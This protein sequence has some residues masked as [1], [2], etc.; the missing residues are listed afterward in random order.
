MAIER[1]VDEIDIDELDI[2]DNSKE[3]LISDESEDE[4]MFD[5]IEDG[6]E[7]ILEDGTMVFGE[8]DLDEDIPLPFTANLA[9]ELD[10][11]DLGRIYSD[12]MGD[13]DDDKSSRKEWMDQYT[14]GLKFLGM[15]FENRTEPFDGASGVIHPLLAESV[16]Q[17]QAQA[18]KEMLPAG[19]PVKTNV[20]GMGTPQTDLQAAR[21][22]EY[23]NYM[24]TQEMKEYDP[25]TDQLLFYLPLSGSAFR[26]V[27]FDQSLG[28]P[29]SRFIP[30]EK[31]I[32]P[33]GTTSLD[34]AVRITHVIDMSM[35]QVRKLQQ[36]GF[37]KKTSMSDSGNDYSDTDQIDEEIDELQ[38][39]KPSGS[40]NDYECELLEVH[41]ELDIPGYEDVDQM[42]E[43]TGIKLPYIVTLSPKQSTILSI[44]RNYVQAD[45][46]RKRIDYFVH[47]KFLPG[48]GFYGFGLTHMI[49]GLSQ[50]STSILRQ[51]IDAGTLANLPAGF[52][53]RGIRIRDNDIPLQPGEFRDMDAPGGSLRD[54]LMPLPFKE[55][56]QTL[57]QL[58]GM[59]V[60]AGR[61]FASVGDMQVGDGNQQ[62]PVGTTIALLE[63]GSRV[64]SAI[65]KRMHYSQR[66]EFNLLARVIKDSPLKSYP[67]MI[68]SGQQQLMAQDFD[69]RIDIIP[70]SDPNIF[71]MSQRV[72][73][74]QEMMQMVQTNPE[75]HG[76]QGTYEAYRRMYEAMG[77]Q[78]IEQLL[79]PPPQPQPASPGM[80]NAA[81]LQMQP[82]QAF[83]DQDHDAHIKSHLLLLKSPVVQNAPPG[84][85]QLMGLIQGHI[86]QHIDLKAREMAQQDPEVTQ[87]QQQIQQMQQQAQMDPMMQQQMQ[88]QMQ[89][90]QQQMQT[91]VE[92]KVAQ[93]TVE[94]LNELEEE[95]QIGQEEDPLVG[96]RKEELDLKDKDIDR[97][98][99]EAQQRI[100]LEGDRIDNNVE[101]GQDRLALQDHT[102]HLKDD[103]A[104][105]RIDLQR[106]AQMAKTAENMAKNFFNN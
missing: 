51:L 64:M 101:L 92:D 66:I 79:P 100:K 61:R 57:L 56:S 106:S 4:L 2:E 60:E 45:M 98:A 20:I 35:N 14:E 75:I 33:Y 13:I 89:Q 36:A 41:V 10:K 69:D 28:R 30:S 87:M 78:Q 25:E 7:S 1:G 102:A 8:D 76:P 46:M 103:V 47:Y 9:E 85:Q 18:Y 34:D 63:K 74:A 22:Q 55:P 27:H 105:E 82:A 48:V 95:L 38:G 83:P 58:L 50:A 62:A 52:K 81:F 19:G 42:G 97:K 99:Q 3:I 44:R 84:Q 88:Q 54:A 5:G 77:V 43:E 93:T 32:V 67:Y 86:Y 71:S 49:G 70:V 31:L 90:M 96:L 6:D 29:V 68:A 24:I 12:L 73:L 11:T 17:F 80:E 94:L 40:S 16:T 26:K 59:L 21:V 65:H 23:M 15:K 37:Y 53:A 91:I 39:V 104:K 72:M